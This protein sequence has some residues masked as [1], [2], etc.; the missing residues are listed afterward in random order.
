MKKENP[1]QINV[2]DLVNRLKMEQ[3]PFAK[4]IG[5][6]PK[7]LPIMKD[8]V[9]DDSSHDPRQGRLNRKR[10]EDLLRIILG[11]PFAF[12]GSEI[13][14]PIQREIGIPFELRPGVFRPRRIAI[15]IFAFTSHHA[16]PL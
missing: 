8:V 11:N 13:P 3:K 15:D 2:S 14:F 7:N 16:R 10:N 1:I 12:V 6:D 9:S 5:R 4:Q